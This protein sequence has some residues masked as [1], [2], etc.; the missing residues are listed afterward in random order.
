M[1]EWVVKLRKHRNYALRERETGY[2]CNNLDSEATVTY[3]FG[4]FCDLSNRT[5][6]GGCCPLTCAVVKHGVVSVEVLTKTK[7]A[8]NTKPATVVWNSA[9]GIQ[10]KRTTELRN[11]SDYFGSIDSQVLQQNIKKLD[12]AFTGFW[13]YNR[14]FPAY[15]KRSNFKSFQYPPGRVKFEGSRVYL[16]GIGWM[17]HHNSRP[18]PEKSKLGTV[19][20]I[21]EADG[22]YLSVI[23]KNQPDLPIPT[24]TADL[25]SNVC[26][27]VGINKLA[28]L[29]DGSHIENPR[30]ATNKATKRRLKIRQRRVNRKKKGSKNRA[31]AG[32]A[33]AKTHKKIRDQRSAY[34]WKAAQKIVDTA[35][36]I[37]H[38]HL[39]VQGMKARCKPQKQKGRFLPNGQSRK[40]GLNRSISDAA[41]GELYAKVA[42]LATKSGKPVFKYPPHHTSQECSACAHVSKS[43]RDGEKFVCES[44]GHIDHADTQA[45]RNGQRRLN[46]RFVSTRHKKP[47]PNRKGIPVDCGKSTPI[48]D[49]ASNGKRN[50]AGNRTSK[51]PIEPSTLRSLN[52]GYLDDI[53]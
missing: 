30:F 21:E 38:E 44:C 7:K 34:Q 36:S 37:G 53:A 16:P 26:F 29:T 50:Q 13:Q 27:D 39:N 4:S 31:K 20:V 25:K 18:F 45:A 52:P 9:S 5:E 2:N 32:V 43:N 3:A 48:S 28:S 15:R 35:D 47:T 42:W 12:A 6:Y 49:F 19:T 40:R 23:V 24:A 41:W 51:Q 22:F 10:Q 8:T 14:G 46:L 33:L 1:T 11:E 17:R